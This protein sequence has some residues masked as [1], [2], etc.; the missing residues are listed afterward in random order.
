MIYYLITNV[1]MPTESISV[2]NTMLNFHL[3]WKQHKVPNVLYCDDSL[4]ADTIVYRY[5]KTVC[6]DNEFLLTKDVECRENGY[7]P[8]LGEVIQL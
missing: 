3:N 2:M 4:Y 1:P 8:Y 5:V 6:G 7:I